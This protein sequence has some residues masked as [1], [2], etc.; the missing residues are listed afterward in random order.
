MTAIPQKTRLFSKKSEHVLKMKNVLQDLIV[1]LIP[2]TEL[3]LN[4]ILLALVATLVIF[5][6]DFNC[7]LIIFKSFCL[8]A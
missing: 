6:E 2:L 1:R 8:F 5:N 3:C 4:S 7:A